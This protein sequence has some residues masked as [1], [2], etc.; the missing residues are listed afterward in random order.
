MRGLEG[1]EE[2]EEA[3]AEGGGEPALGFELWMGLRLSFCVCV[4]VC[5]WGVVIRFIG[6]HACAH[7]VRNGH[8][9]IHTHTHTHS[10]IYTYTHIYIYIYTHIYTPLLTYLLPERLGPS[11]G[12]PALAGV[13]RQKAADDT[14]WM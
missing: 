14:L 6:R 3:V 11:R 10:N 9:H 1:G 2:G 7:T 5:M 13:A 4:C 12:R 8:T